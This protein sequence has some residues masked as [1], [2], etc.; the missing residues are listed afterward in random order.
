VLYMLSSAALHPCFVHYMCVAKNSVIHNVQLSKSSA[1]VPK[2]HQVLAMQSYYD[3][4]YFF[5]VNIHSDIR[6][7]YSIYS[8]IQ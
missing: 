2:S 6:V 4:S 7:D 3:N 5:A 1:D 8:T